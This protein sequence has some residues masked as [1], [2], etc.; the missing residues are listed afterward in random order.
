[1]GQM[2][3]G[4]QTGKANHQNFSLDL[5]GKGD[6]LLNEIGEPGKQQ[7]KLSELFQGN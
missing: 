4:Q 6:V 3:Y 7:G 5:I 1:M 2:C